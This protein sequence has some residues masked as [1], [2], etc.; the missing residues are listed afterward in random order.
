[1]NRRKKWGILLP[2]F[3]LLLTLLPPTYTEAA[4]V[5]NSNPSVLAKAAAVIDVETGRILYEKNGNEKMR[6]ASLT[7][8]MTAIVAIEEGKLNDVVE[9][10]AHAVGTEGSS[11]YLRQGEKLTLEQLL[12][13]LML[14]SGNDAAVTIA[15]H[16]G[17]SVPGFVQL[18]NE[19]AEYLGLSNTHFANP[20]GL[21]QQGH[22]S[23]ADDLA[24]LTAYSLHNEMFRKIV[25]TRTKTIPQEGQ[26]WD[27]KLINKNKMLVFYSGA[28][29]VKTGYTKLAKRC[30]VS[31]ATREGRQI[32]VVTLN[33]PNDWQDHAA[34]LDY[35]LKHFNRVQLVSKGEKV[36]G[37]FVTLQP[38]YYPLTE[39]E[40]E[41]IRKT[42]S[43]GFLQI[44]LGDTLIGKV[45][46]GKQAQQT[47][48]GSFN[49]LQTERFF[50]FLKEIIWGGLIH[51]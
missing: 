5:K 15:D 20:H 51:G 47:S 14:R 46:L 6:V 31:S 7:K 32:A 25:G 39:N 34:L 23:T 41:Q 30:L 49:R 28:D 42:I 22:Y 26:N 45:T 8:I 44:Y 24:K 43:A 19:K 33:D 48:V 1:M 27:R 36:A 38:F 40:K 50:T 21:D 4:P 2:L 3:G 16:V 29:G 13:G 17:G 37:D 35:G 9:V 11:I 12:Y 10:P 18:M